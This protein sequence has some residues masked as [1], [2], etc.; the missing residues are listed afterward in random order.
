MQ[1]VGNLVCKTCGKP[2]ADGEFCSWCRQFDRGFDRAFAPYLYAGL[3]RDLILSCKYENHPELARAMGGEMAAYFTA[4]YSGQAVDLI[5]PVPIHLSRYRERGYN[6]AGLIAREVGRILELPV[7]EDW[8][9]RSQAT[10]A[11]KTLSAAERK[12]SLQGVFKIRDQVQE[13]AFAGRILL[14]D[15]VLTTGATA[16]A[17][18]R[19]L[20]EG[21]EREILVLTFATRG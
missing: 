5:V 10:Q 4:A 16:E 21:K 1:P 7:A 6:Q 14:I 12:T 17:C 19:V 9:V 18:A 15:D 3:V 2:I 8:L 11:L 13:P 20:K